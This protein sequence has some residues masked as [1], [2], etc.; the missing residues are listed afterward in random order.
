MTEGWI[1]Y[2]LATY[3]SSPVCAWQQLLLIPN[4][5]TAP[6]WWEAD[7]LA[8]SRSGYCTEV[9]VKCTMEDWRAD[10]HKGKHGHPD[11]PKLIKKF[12]YA[13]PLELMKRYGEVWTRPGS[14]I[15]GIDYHPGDP[16]WPRITVLRQPEVVKTARKLTDKELILFG[17]TSMIRYW[18]WAGKRHAADFVPQPDNVGDGE[19]L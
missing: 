15:I 1:Q 9:E 19:A 8:I 14:G 18:N 13:G 16:T 17:R 10:Q 4:C 6:C 5:M 3:S 11:V 12:Y 2:A 7:L